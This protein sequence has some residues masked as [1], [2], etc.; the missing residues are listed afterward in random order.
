MLIF[1]SLVPVFF[2]EPVTKPTPGARRKEQARLQELMRGCTETLNWCFDADEAKKRAK[3]EEKPIL[4]YV[5]CTDDDKGYASAL[6]SIRA[7]GIAWRDNGLQK[8]LLFR[9][10]PLSYRE[11]E[12]LIERRFV[13]L[14]LT[15]K[16]SQPWVS[17]SR[18]KQGPVGRP[19]IVGEGLHYPRSGGGTPKRQAP[20]QD[21]PHRYISLIILWLKTLGLSVPGR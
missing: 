10:G 7:P 21:S 12:E 1:A 9:A 13:P 3:K 19:G 2:A 11:I 16:Q 6:E 8:D 20:S 14:C 15:Y 18:R 5:Q 17:G 4:L